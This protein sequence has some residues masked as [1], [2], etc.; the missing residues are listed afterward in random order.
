MQLRTPV[1]A[2]AIAL[3]IGGTYVIGQQQAA[4][5]PAASRPA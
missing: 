2:S 1:L 5:A 3:A 4:E